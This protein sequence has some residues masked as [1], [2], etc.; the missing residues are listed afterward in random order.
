MRPQRNKR[1]RDKQQR[2]MQQ[3]DMRIGQIQLNTWQDRQL[4]E[5]AHHLRKLQTL[6]TMSTPTTTPNGALS[7]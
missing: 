1:Q 7:C 6:Q 5:A 3:R 4:P 2:D